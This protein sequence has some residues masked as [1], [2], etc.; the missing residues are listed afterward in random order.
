[1]RQLIA[2][3]H[4]DGTIT[5]TEC[6]LLIADLFGPLNRVANMAGTFGCFLSKWTA[7]AHQP[8]AM[9]CRKRKSRKTSVEA[10]VGDVFDV[11]NGRCRNSLTL[12]RR[13][14][15]PVRTLARDGRL[16]STSGESAV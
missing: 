4:G 10:T 7:Q 15:R 6:R 13:A 1:M 16:T 5:E 2:L 9:Q 8:I 11:A 3:W 12:A 14:A